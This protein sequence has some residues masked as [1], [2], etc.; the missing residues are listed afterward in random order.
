[1]NDS[2]PTL[3]ELGDAVTPPPAVP[4]TAPARDALIVRPQRTQVSHVPSCLD[5]HVPT[6]HPVRAIW[7]VIAGLD[8]TTLEARV[9][10]NA[11][12]G[13][14]PATDPH[15]LLALWV[16]AISQ[17]EGRA[18]EIA[19]RAQSDDVYRWL[20][21]GVP[22]GERKLADFRAR[23][24]EVFDGLI[25]QVLA[26][27]LTEDLVD[28]TRLAQDGTRV[29]AS[30]GTGSFKRLPTL[31]A[32][33]AAAQAHLAAVLAAA[34]DPAH[35]TVAQA[36]AVRGATERAARIERAQVRVRELAAARGIDADPADPKRAPRASITDPDA[37][38]MKMG[39]GGF[40]P[41][42]NV[43]FATAADASGVVLG[44]EVTTRGSDQ[45]E[46]A[47]M[48]AQVEARTGRHIVEHL[49]D[50]GYAQHDEIEAAAAAGTRVTAPLPKKRAA[51]NGR[52]A[53]EQS[54][55]VREWH[56]HMESDAGKASY[57]D[58][59]RVAEL[60]NARA[61]TEGVL[62]AIGVRGTKAVL[63]CALLAALTINVERLIHLRAVRAATT[64]VATATS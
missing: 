49:A 45:G 48:R 1:M 46:L 14:R 11:R 40:R 54:A 47:P 26:V 34:D 52:R 39:D 38:V 44:V 33:L 4:R 64:Q 19:R 53:R 42:Y 9:E 16:Y 50:A 17:G 51:P 35:R 57:R 2:R 13:G 55:A 56:A 37:T 6:D 20:R 32:A 43:Q 31:D 59:G 12:Q 5:D 58:R 25:T 8:L 30:A 21:G 28:A 18:A 10:S 23:H 15:V 61:K 41:A 3:F 62:D 29:R 36:A 24:G 60:T 22:A 63:T 7:D 27:L